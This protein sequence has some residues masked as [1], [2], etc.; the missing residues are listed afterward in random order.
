MKDSNDY[1]LSLSTCDKDSKSQI[2]TFNLLP[3]KMNA[4]KNAKTDKFLKTSNDL[5]DQTWMFQYTKSN[6]D[7]ILYSLIN[8]KDTYTIKDWSNGNKIKKI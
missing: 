8:K 7:R 2:W 1:G 5:N 6:L 3:N 4:L